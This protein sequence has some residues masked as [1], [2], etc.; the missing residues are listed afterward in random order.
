MA[1]QSW[2][3]RVCCAISVGKEE[4]LAAGSCPCLLPGGS[5]HSQLS[6]QAKRGHA[7]HLPPLR[8]QGSA[9]DWPC[10]AGCGSVTGPGPRPWELA[11]SSRALGPR[12]L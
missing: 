8:L 6:G 10:Q 9:W 11:P 2:E 1:S 3:L 5:T 4:L 12:W 7:G